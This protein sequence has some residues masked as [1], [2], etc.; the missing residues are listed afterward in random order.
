[1][2]RRR[3]QLARKNGL[4]GLGSCP[5]SKHGDR[6]ATLSKQIST[7]TAAG[8]DRAGSHEGLVLINK[9]TF[10]SPCAVLEQG[11]KLRHAS[12]RP[13]A[14]TRRES[15]GQRSVAGARRVMAGCRTE[16]TNIDIDASAFRYPLLWLS[17]EDRRHY[18]S[19]GNK[20]RRGKNPRA[21]F[22]TLD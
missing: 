20:I 3:P 9:K 2:G 21:Y 13:P 22:G 15:A 5:G 6:G 14:E 8:Q 11:S 16:N 7:L 4:L 10:V 18:Y 12:I 1:M 17:L 19:I